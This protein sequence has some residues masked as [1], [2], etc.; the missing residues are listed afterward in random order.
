MKFANNW[1]QILT[2]AWSVRLIFLGAVLSALPVFI[3]LVNADILGVSP[4]V[5]AVIAALVNM[6]ALLARLLIQPGARFIR[7]ESGAVRKRTMA[8]IG[9]V[10]IAAAVFIGP[11]EGMRTTA[12]PDALARNIPT[13][14]Y[15]ETRGV[16]LGDVYTEAECDAMLA[17]AVGEFKAA[18]A[19]CLPGLDEYPEGVQVAFISWSYNVGTGAACR[20]TLA[21]LARAGDLAAAC[22]E[23][24]RWNRAGGR[25]VRGLS[26]RRGAERTLCLK[27]LGAAA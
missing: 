15:G 25:V 22:N 14:C 1:K 8:G 2:G 21:R 13:V 26:N 6:L 11:W 23:L 17:R 16:Q 24:P 7:S 18:L 19:Q 5:F 4:L 9:A 10:A 12:Y 27:S 3:S 20:S